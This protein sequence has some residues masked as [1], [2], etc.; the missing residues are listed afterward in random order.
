[1]YSDPEILVLCIDPKATKHVHAH[2]DIYTSMF[3]Y[4][5]F[6]RTIT[7]GMLMDI[8]VLCLILDMDNVSSLSIRL[9]LD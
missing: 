1:M 5:L 9:A 3:L 8:L 6:V 2:S 4:V 7:K